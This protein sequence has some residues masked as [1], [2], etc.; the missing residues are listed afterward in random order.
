MSLLNRFVMIFENIMCFVHTFWNTRDQ[1]RR[2]PRQHSFKISR[3]HK[4]CL[5]ERVDN[6]DKMSY[7]W[8][9][10][11]HTIHVPLGIFRKIEPFRRMWHYLKLNWHMNDIIIKLWTTYRLTWSCFILLR[12]ITATSSIE[13]ST[14][15]EGCIV[16]QMCCVVKSVVQI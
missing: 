16:V 12:N 14:R 4:L 3:I 9:K 15:F 8:G 10:H 1:V 2:I 13:R 11:N 7:V 6:F 5:E